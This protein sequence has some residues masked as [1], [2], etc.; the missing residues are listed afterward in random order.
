[1]LSN[2]LN[3]ILG[4][5]LAAERGREGREG[6]RAKSLGFKERRYWLR[7][8]V[9]GGV[10]DATCVYRLRLNPSPSIDSTWRSLRPVNRERLMLMVS[11]A[12]SSLGFKV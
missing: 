11:A 7:Q 1:M 12:L 5:E 8:R 4:S 9:D 6:P 2:A 10:T 3:P